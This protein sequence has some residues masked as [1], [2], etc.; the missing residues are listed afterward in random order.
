M[1][2][3]VAINKKH[4]KM[5]QDLGL[6]SAIV[7]P[8]KLREQI[9]G[10]I[11]F[12]STKN[13]FQYTQTDLV[14]A[15]DIASHAASAIENARLYKEAN[16]LNEKLNQKAKERSEELA[17]SNTELE[18]EMKLRK[19]VTDDLRELE[20]RQSIIAQLGRRFISESNLMTMM[21]EIVSVI[22]AAL[23]VGHC[24]LFE[25]IHDKNRLLLRAA[26]GFG[27]ASVGSM[28]L[29]INSEFQEGYAFLNNESLIHES[30]E[31]GGKFKIHKILIDADI[32]YGSSI[33]IAGRNKPFGVLSIYSS[34]DKKISQNDLHFVHSILILFSDAVERV[35]LT[36]KLTNLKSANN[37]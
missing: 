31:A 6:K 37:Y 15:E 17:I 29:E 2:G 4:L 23:G 32:K 28:E 3:T 9:L 19:H 25:F 1:L 22:P 27:F 13:S 36:E 10:A 24:G 11:S 7:V 26:V 14:F 34:Q 8:L 20:N 5:I 12:I 33:V 16:L 21:Q 30:Y 35:Q 18:V